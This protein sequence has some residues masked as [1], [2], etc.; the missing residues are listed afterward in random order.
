M[1]GREVVEAA[2]ADWRTAP[3]S[4]RVR[5]MLGFLEK[6]TLHPASLG[7]GDAALLRQAGISAQAIE[8]AVYTCVAFNAIVR[9]ADTFEF[10][11]SSPEAFY[12]SGP[13]MYHG[14]YRM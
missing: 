11:V 2:L 8:D 3:V 13:A 5:A 14:G 9:L 6:M 1:L 7:P 10:A 4:E 12:Q